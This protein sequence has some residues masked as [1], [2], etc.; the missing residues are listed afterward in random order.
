MG[1]YINPKDMSKEE[2][3]SDNCVHTNGR[4]PPKSHLET[5]EDSIDCI[6]V[7][8]IDN[9]MFTAAGICVN[10][11]ELHAFSQRDGRLK[12]WFLVPLEK[13]IGEGFIKLED[14]TP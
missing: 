5:S 11:S 3:L 4:T 14:I 7:C 6:W 1:F 2:W 10:A 12:T 9:L 13:L 8:M